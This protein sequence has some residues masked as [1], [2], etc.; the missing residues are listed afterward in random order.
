MTPYEQGFHDYMEKA[1]ING[2]LLKRIGSGLADAGSWAKGKAMP[3]GGNVEKLWDMAK[4]NKKKIGIG[5]LGVG[6]GVIG[7]S[8]L[9]SALAGSPEP[10]DEELAD[11]YA[12]QDAE[13]SKQTSEPYIPRAPAPPPPPTPKR[14]RPYEGWANGDDDLSPL[15]RQLQQMGQEG[16]GNVFHY[17]DMPSNI[18][19]QRNLIT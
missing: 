15:V 8:M 14:E 12:R 1:A 17:G 2:G 4:N 18:H 19:Y 9:G 10:Y 13:K 11:Y 7:S 3:P 6:A 16:G 5:A